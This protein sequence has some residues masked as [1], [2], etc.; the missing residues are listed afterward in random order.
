MNT[1]KEIREL[2]QQLAIMAGILGV[3]I[4]SVSNWENGK[5]F[6]KREHLKKYADYFQT[7]QRDVGIG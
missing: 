2:K 5:R 7:P 1:E 4:A 6:P 3:S